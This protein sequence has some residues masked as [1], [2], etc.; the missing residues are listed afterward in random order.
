M[1]LQFPWTP[2]VEG[3]GTVEALGAGVSTFQQGQEVY[4]ILSNSYAE[5]AIALAKDIQPKPSNLT[6]EQAATVPVGALTAWSA[7]IDTANVQAGRRGWGICGP[8]GTLE[9]GTRNR[10][11]LGRESR[12][13]EVPR[14][15]I[16]DRL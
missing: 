11:C 4:G 16:G 5:Y 12:I 15:R 6:F 1:P 14:R 7:V 10:D 9:G 3:A 8:T 2:G 13:C